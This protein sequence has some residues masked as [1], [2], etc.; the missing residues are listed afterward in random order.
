LI[1]S[2]FLKQLQSIQLYDSSALFIS[3]ALPPIVASG[4]HPLGGKSLNVVSG[5]VTPY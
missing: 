3:T 1:I 2:F 5:M 4:L